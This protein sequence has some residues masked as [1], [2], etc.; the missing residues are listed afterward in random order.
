MPRMTKALLT[1]KSS[2][3]LQTNTFILTFTEQKTSFTP[4]LVKS[5]KASLKP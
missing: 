2:H 1:H 4:A 3:V 5:S